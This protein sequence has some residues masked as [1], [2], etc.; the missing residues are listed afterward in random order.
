[1][2]KQ[3]KCYLNGLKR[4][5]IVSRDTKHFYINILLLDWTL[6]KIYKGIGSIEVDRDGHKGR[7]V[8]RGGLWDGPV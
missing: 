3:I 4:Y 2:L 7:E 6:V 1:M 8:G 5:Q